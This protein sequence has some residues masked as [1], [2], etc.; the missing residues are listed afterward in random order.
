VRQPPDELLEDD[1]HL[2][3]GQGLADQGVRAHKGPFLV[4]EGAGL[5][6][7]AFGDRRLA[8]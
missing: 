4:V 8:D 2:E 5:V 1:A 7:D 3:L 6:E